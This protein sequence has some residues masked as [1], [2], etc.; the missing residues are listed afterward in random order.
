MGASSA[1][2]QRMIML[3]YGL[4]AGNRMSFRDMDERTGACIFMIDSEPSGIKPE[5]V[6]RS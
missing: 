3:D 6:I 2:A 4:L 5:S 1:F